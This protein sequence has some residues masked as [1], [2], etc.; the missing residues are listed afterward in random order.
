MQLR[1][2]RGNDMMKLNSD[3][4]HEFGLSGE[5]VPGATREAEEERRKNMYMMNFKPDHPGFHEEH[6]DRNKEGHG[7]AERSSLMSK[8]R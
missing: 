6:G 4:T 8:A 2:Q 7:A 5:H 3:M 1:K